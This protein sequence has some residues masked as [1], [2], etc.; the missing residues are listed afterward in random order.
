MKQSVFLRY[1]P[2]LLSFIL[3]I[4]LFSCKTGEDISNEYSTYIFE[5]KTDSKSYFIKLDSIDK[6]YAK[7]RFY[8]IDNGLTLRPRI[9]EAVLHKNKCKVTLPNDDVITFRIKS[10][11]DNKYEGF[12]LRH[13]FSKRKKFSLYPYLCDEKLTFNLN[14]YKQKLF[15]VERITNVKYAE[16]KGFWTS[17]PDDTIDVGSIVK[18]G[19]FNSL[20]KKDLVLDMDIYIPK[21][22]TLSQRPL[23]MFIH[24]GAFFIGDKATEPYQRW[25]THFAS[26]GYICV[27]INYRMGFRVNSKAIERTAYQATQD[28]HAAMRFLLSKKDI[29]RIDPDNLFVGGASAGSITAMNL[30]YMR[31]ENRPESSYSSLFLEDLGNLETSGNK[32]YNKFKIKAVANLWG[33]IYD[34]NILKNSQAA[35]I[36]FHGDKDVILPYRFGYPF[37]ALGEFNKVFFD[38]MYGSSYIHEKAVELGIRSEL[39]TFKGQGHTL[40]L[41]ENRQLNNNFYTIQNNIVDF[42]YDELIPYPAYIKQNKT[43]NQ[44]FE[45]DTTYVTASDWTVLGGYIINES[46]GKVKVS[47][48]DDELQQELRVRGYYKNGAGFDDVFVNKD[49]REDEDNPHK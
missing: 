40:H 1:F 21:D 4:C 35:I 13:G 14:R 5:N 39:H 37:R 30:T 48:F 7:G 28:A 43:E 46:K 17:I 41:D 10:Q 19:L 23:M 26:L 24:G 20:K 45:I 36:S 31:N 6:S 29:Y 22:D 34:L 11:S 16:A 44:I 33:S 42:F 38:E 8:L 18:I 25:C 9:F 3:L 12:I 32:I 15:D 27:S 2:I 47:W 49:V